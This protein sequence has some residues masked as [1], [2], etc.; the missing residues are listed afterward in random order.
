MKNLFLTISLIALV[1]I[2]F[3][4]CNQAP[5][6]YWDFEPVIETEN[7]KISSWRV[8]G[9]GTFLRIDEKN[10]PDSLNG[11]ITFIDSSPINKNHTIG[12]WEFDQMTLY[13]V[14]TN[15]LLWKYARMDYANKIYRE[16][17]DDWYSKRGYS[18]KKNGEYCEIGEMIYMD[19]SACY[20]IMK[21]GT[22]YKIDGVN[23]SNSSEYEESIDECVEQ[24]REENSKKDR[25]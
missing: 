24:I 17:C 19:D 6:M 9:S 4:S 7:L 2:S 11:H 18:M 13:G 1:A 20:Y 8:A 12:D 21:D 16:L 3:S 14:E 5:K 22:S 23:V 10:S 15:S 25:N